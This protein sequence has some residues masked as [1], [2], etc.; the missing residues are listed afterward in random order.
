VQRFGGRRTGGGRRG[1]CAL[2]LNFGVKIERFRVCPDGTKVRGR[3]FLTWGSPF[4]TYGM[5]R[6]QPGDGLRF[7]ESDKGVPGNGS[8]NPPERIDIPRKRFGINFKKFWVSGNRFWFSR[9]G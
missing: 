3:G 9:K 8:G 5:I 2:F 4:G 7:P 1:F 6:R